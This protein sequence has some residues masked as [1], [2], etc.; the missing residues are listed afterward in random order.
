MAMGETP[1]TVIGNLTSD[2]ELKFTPS[3]AALAKFTVASTPRHFDRDAGQYKDGTAMF[4]RCSAWRGLAEH[5]TESLTKGSRVIVSGRLRQFDWQTDQGENRSM[6]ALEVD[7]I[8][9]SLKFATATSTK[10]QPSNNGG[11]RTVPDPNNGEPWN[12]A[13]AKAG[14]D[15]PPF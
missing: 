13:A 12:V 1:I 15:E 6:L 14:G 4:M 7:D 2:P 5:V 3:G 10:A 11:G 8:G 9:P